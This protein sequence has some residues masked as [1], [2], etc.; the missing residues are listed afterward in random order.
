MSPT[1][2]TSTRSTPRA[3]SR[4]PARTRVGNGGR[5]SG[6]YTLP[7]VGMTIPSPLV[8]TGFWGTL[9][10]ATLLGAIDPPLAVLVGAGVA[11]ARHRSS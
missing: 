3:A 1:R 5:G 8:E 10:G 11:V 9:V 2:S 4:A 6:G 7:V